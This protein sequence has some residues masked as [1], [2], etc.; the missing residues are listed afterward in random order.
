MLGRLNGLMDIM[1]HCGHGMTLRLQAELLGNPLP[2][3]SPAHSS[4]TSATPTGQV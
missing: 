3:S 4:Q 1:E 2:L